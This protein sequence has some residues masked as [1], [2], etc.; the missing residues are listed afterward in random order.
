MF[1]PSKVSFA[2]SVD[3][4]IDRNQEQ[5]TSFHKTCGRQTVFVVIVRISS[6]VC[7]FC[8]F[9]WDHSWNSRTYG[10]TLMLLKFKS[11]VNHSFVPVDKKS[12]V[13]CEMAISSRISV[14]RV[15]RLAVVLY[16]QKYIFIIPTTT[17]ICRNCLVAGLDLCLKFICYGS[18]KHFHVPT[19]VSMDHSALSKVYIIR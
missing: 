11:A 6:S 10:R 3:L 9:Y 17:L 18:Y 15:D 19:I 2:F 4:S 13:M 7:F 16:W 1:P 12:L 8:F 14:L 5:M